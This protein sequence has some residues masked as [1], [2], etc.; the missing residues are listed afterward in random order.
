MWQISQ[1][2]MAIRTLAAPLILFAGVG[3]AHA[4]DITTPKMKWQGGQLAAICDDPEGICFTVEMPKYIGNVEGIYPAPIIRNAR[5]SWVA[6]SKYELFVCAVVVNSP[7]VAC[8]KIGSDSF[9]AAYADLRMKYS[10]SGKTRIAVLGRGSAAAGHAL[11]INA[12]KEINRQYAPAVAKLQGIIEAL[13]HV[14]APYA[15]RMTVYDPRVHGDP[16]EEGCKWQINGWMC[17]APKPYD[18]CIPAA[19]AKWFCKIDG[20]IPEPELDAAL[21]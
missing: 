20:E 16:P 3:N 18:D 12:E 13:T 17:P 2:K 14:D 19:G 4:V 6:R 8:T 11:L 21:E 5:A 9:P 15:G 7:R 1:F 10:L